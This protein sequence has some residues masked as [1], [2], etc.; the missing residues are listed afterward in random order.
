VGS[1]I[2]PKELTN[3]ENGGIVLVLQI[4]RFVLEVGSNLQES[5]GNREEKSYGN[6][7]ASPP[8]DQGRGM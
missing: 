2:I 1:I 8:V 7:R 5:S 4:F 6:S 3:F